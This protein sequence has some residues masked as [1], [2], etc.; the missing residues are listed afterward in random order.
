LC[1]S[2]LLATTSTECTELDWVLTKELWVNSIM[3]SILQLFITHSF[4][5]P[6]HVDINATQKSELSDDILMQRIAEASG[7]ANKVKP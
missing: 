5:Q 6:Y 1:T 2:I 3:Y 4:H 7:S